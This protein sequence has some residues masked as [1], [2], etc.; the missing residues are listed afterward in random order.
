MGWTTTYTY[1]LLIIGLV[2][3][4]IFAVIESRAAHPLIPRTILNAKLGFVL[5]CIACGWGTFGIW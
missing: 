5:G 4:G 1:I 3:L 2:L